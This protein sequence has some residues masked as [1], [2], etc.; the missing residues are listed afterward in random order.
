MHFASTLAV[1]SNLIVG[2]SPSWCPQ[3]QTFLITAA[4]VSHQRL[5]KAVAST[6]RLSGFKKIFVDDVCL[7]SQLHDRVES[8]EMRLWRLCIPSLIQPP[9]DPWAGESI[10]Q[11]SE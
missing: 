1:L 11:D 7:L 9:T 2:G 4:T 10:R 6:S 3:Y 8:D 5:Y